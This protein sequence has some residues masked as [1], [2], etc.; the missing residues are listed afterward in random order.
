MARLDRLE[1]TAK[2]VAQIAAAIGREFSFELLS[3]VVQKSE[4][5]VT[6]SLARL[7]DAELVFCRG[8][9]PRAVFLFKHALL[10]DAAYGTLLRGS[11][12]ALHTRIAGALEER[13]PEVVEA[14][15]E[16][17]AH[18]FSEAALYE[19]ALDYWQRAGERA[20]RNA[21]YQEAIAHFDKALTAAGRLA[22]SPTLQVLRLRLCIA[23]G[24]ALIHAKG[25]AAPETTAAFSRA[26]DLAASVDD[27][28]ERLPAHYGL[29]AGSW[30]R[31]ELEQARESAQAFVE[32]TADQPGSAEAGVAHRLLGSTSWLR[33]DFQSAR[34]HLEKSLS[35]YDSER[36]HELAFRFAQDTGV[37]ALV[38]LGMTLWPLGMIHRAAECAEQAVERAVESRQIA[39]LAFAHGYK[40]LFEMMRQDVS[41]AGEH[42]T[43]LL[44]LA[45]EHAM[46]QWFAIGT[47]AQG[48]ARW[49]AGECVYGEKGMADAMALFKEQRIRF[50]VPLCA[51]LFAAIEAHSGRIDVALATLDDTLAE[52]ERSG[53]HHF[54]AE[55]HRQ[56]GELLMR[57]LRI[58]QGEAALKRAIE[59]AR[60]QAARTFELRAS[61][62]LARLW[63]DQGKPARARELLAPIRGSFTEDFDMRE[64]REAC[65]LLGELG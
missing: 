63:R 51:V 13:W 46:P 14:Q 42:A 30:V 16:L 25:Y 57:L 12:Q 39:T 22:E 1:A 58:E 23:Q 7:T 48:W 47:F 53:Q 45:S 19:R 32:A 34:A 62:R 43:A 11:R 4:A 18:H 2:E 27:T 61:T 24:Q 6:A 35:I 26:R 9:P 56:Q 29:W 65:D 28:A 5:E 50:P 37:S 10:R 59:T 36:D 3:M 21:A 52:V 41:R 17:L 49:H 54:T 20:L 8:T 38:V 44:A 31:G 33:G 55:I 15:P 64:V 40:A 60:L